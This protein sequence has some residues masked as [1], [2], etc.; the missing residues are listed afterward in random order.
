M[1]RSDKQTLAGALG[2]VMQ[3]ALC[4]KPVWQCILPHVL[5]VL[6]LCASYSAIVGAIL[7]RDSFSI[8]CLHRV[9]L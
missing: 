3:L 2:T 4:S 5:L 8:L 7:H 6:V 9:W 1:S